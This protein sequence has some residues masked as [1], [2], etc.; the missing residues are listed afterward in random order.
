MTCSVILYLM[1][2]IFLCFR[3]DNFPV[4]ISK[5]PSFSLVK[6]TLTDPKLTD[7]TTSLKKVTLAD[8]TSMYDGKSNWNSDYIWE[9]TFIVV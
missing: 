9:V 8:G 5:S 6:Q 1:G 7:A 3:V 2:N 4:E